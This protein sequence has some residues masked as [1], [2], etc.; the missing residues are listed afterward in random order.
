MMIVMIM[1]ITVEEEDKAKM[2]IFSSRE[3]QRMVLSFFCFFDFEVLSEY[4]NF[5]INHWTTIA[6][7]ELF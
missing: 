2:L 3:Y 5:N 4:C 1:M 6:S 7:I